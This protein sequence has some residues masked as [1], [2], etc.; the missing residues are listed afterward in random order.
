MSSKLTDTTFDPW[1]E[2]QQ[3]Q[4]QSKLNKQFG[5][6]ATF[7]GSMRDFNDDADVSE[8]AL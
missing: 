8:M 4:K 3:H 6:T 2:I 7:I 5:A 1:Q